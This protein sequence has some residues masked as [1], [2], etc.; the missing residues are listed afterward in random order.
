MRKATKDELSGISQYIKS[1]SEPT[2]I[3]IFDV[4][5]KTSLEFCQNFE[6]ADIYGAS[7]EDVDSDF[8]NDIKSVISSNIQKDMEHDEY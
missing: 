8:S 4:T 3:N 7:Y 5:Q 1:V 2:G 6:K